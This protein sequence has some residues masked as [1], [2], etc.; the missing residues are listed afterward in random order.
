MDDIDEVKNAIKKIDSN[1]EQYSKNALTFYNS[2][3][4]KTTLLSI[5]ERNIK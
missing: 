4:V 5:A 3:D 2:F 1:Y